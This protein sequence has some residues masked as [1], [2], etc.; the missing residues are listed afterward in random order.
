MEIILIIW[1]LGIIYAVWLFFFPIIL[2]CKLNG[3]I[4][5]LKVDEGKVV[6]KECPQCAELIKYKARICKYC[7]YKF[8][9][10]ETLSLED[11]IKREIEIKGKSEVIMCNICGTLNP[12]NAVNCRNPMCDNNLYDSETI[13][14]Q[15]V[16][17]VDKYK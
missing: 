16:E 12:K 4:N 9:E 8:K 11:R 2:I 10:H 14:I 13:K 15:N 1:I 3:I 7:G 17:D 5:L 6:K